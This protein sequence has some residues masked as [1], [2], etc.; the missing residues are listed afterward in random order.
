LA[1]PRINIWPAKSDAVLRP[2]RDLT[3]PKWKFITTCTVPPRV[4]LGT[5]TTL[6]P[7]PIFVRVV[8]ASMAA[9]DGSNASPAAKAAPPEILQHPRDVRVAGTS[10]RSAVVE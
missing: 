2:C 9:G 3:S 4:F 1:V 8:R 7:G 10:A 5:R 6:I